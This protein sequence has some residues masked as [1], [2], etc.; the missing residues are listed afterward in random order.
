VRDVPTAVVCEV[1]RSTYL[2]NEF[3]FLF[4]DSRRWCHQ[5]SKIH[6]F[7]YDFKIFVAK[8]HDLPNVANRPTI[9]GRNHVDVPFGQISFGKYCTAKFACGKVHLLTNVLL[10]KVWASDSQ[11]DVLRTKYF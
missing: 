5:G 1:Q 6:K 3:S 4:P 11:E 9:P 8:L 10:A 2:Q 7:F